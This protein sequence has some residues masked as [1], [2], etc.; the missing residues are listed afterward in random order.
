MARGSRPGR[1]PSKAG[2]HSAGPKATA[3]FL[4]RRFLCKGVH[5]YTGSVPVRLLFIMDSFPARP[6]A[7]SKGRGIF[8]PFIYPDLNARRI[9]AKPSVL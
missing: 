8:H 6:F 5:T 2:Q 1:P 3:A 7:P 4:R 9:A